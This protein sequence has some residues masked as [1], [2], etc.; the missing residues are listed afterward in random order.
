MLSKKILRE[1]DSTICYAEENL[2]PVYFD[3]FDAMT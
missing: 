2:F 1:N 3:D